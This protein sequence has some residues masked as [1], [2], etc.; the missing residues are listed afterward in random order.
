MISAPRRPTSS[1]GLSSR[2]APPLDLPFRFFLI[3]IAVFT[4]LML[5]SPWETVLLLGSFTNPVLV[6]FVHLQTVG[7]IAATIF[8]A[9]YQ[10]LPVILQAPLA[11]V[12][13][14]RLS[15][16]LIFPGLFAFLSG[17][18]TDWLP[19]LAIG[20]I[21]LTASF[22]LYAGITL[23]TVIRAPH[24][25]VI[26]WHIAL[27]TLGLI[28]AT[29][30][31]LVLVLTLA[32]GTPDSHFFAI[33]AAHI[34]LMLGGWVTPLLTGVAYRLI[35]MFTLA[36]DAFV[37]PLAWA[38]LTLTAIGSWLLTCCVLFTLPSPLMI[39]AALMLFSG[40]ILFTLQILHL[41]RHRRR[42]TLDIHQPFAVTAA[43]CI[44]IAVLLLLIGIVRHATIDSPLWPTAGWL[45]IAGWAETAIQGFLYKIGPFL[46]WLHRYAPLAGRQRV[47]RLEQ[48]FSRRIAIAG[49]FFWSFG[50]LTETIALLMNASLLA[51][52]AA[53]TL[54]LGLLAF[55]SNAVQVGAHWRGRHPFPLPSTPGAP[56][57]SPPER[58]TSLPRPRVPRP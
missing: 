51:H 48:L 32:A 44:L 17:L 14:A 15:W 35:G 58:P 46:T 50:I 56:P 57:N 1:P 42:R 3:T 33:L 23:T 40:L 8:G 43:T 18:L 45:A 49:W 19:L 20:G 4:L 53:L 24:H 21:L 28:G 34:L 39:L 36:E 26:T 16:W 6:T 52:L 13:L 11:S 22:W 9:S 2:H 5:L 25:D 37:E 38:E 12:R 27:A 30:L 31:G 55:L 29:T 54:S 10:L 41:Y 47:P 7:V